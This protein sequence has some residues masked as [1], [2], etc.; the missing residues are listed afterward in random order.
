MIEVP[1]I[2]A[3]EG[4]DDCGACTLRHMK[5]DKIFHGSSFGVMLAS[6]SVVTSLGTSACTSMTTQ[7]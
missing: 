2:D 6:A 3:P 1:T 5:E 4:G 7:V